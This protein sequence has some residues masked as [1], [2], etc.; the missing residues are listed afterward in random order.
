VNVAA[1]ERSVKHTLLAVVGSKLF[2]M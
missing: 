1:G 2:R